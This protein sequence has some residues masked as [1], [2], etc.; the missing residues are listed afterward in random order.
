M[1]DGFLRI[2]DRRT[3][4]R[5]ATAAAFLVVGATLLFQ[6][7]PVMAQPPST[8]PTVRVSYHE[9]FWI[10]GPD[11]TALASLTLTPV[12]RTLPGGASV[13]LRMEPFIDGATGAQVGQ[14]SWIVPSP[15]EGHPDEATTQLASNPEE[16]HIKVKVTGLTQ[17]TSA[18]AALFAGPFQIGTVTVAREKVP[19]G[20]T[21]TRPGEPAPLPL[22][23]GQTAWL[24]ITNADSLAYPI[25]WTLRLGG[26]P[27]HGRMMVPAG[28]VVDLPLV[29][30]ADQMPSWAENLLRPG[31]R[32][33][34]LELAYEPVAG[35]APVVVRSFPV[36]VS[37][38]R[39]GPVVQAAISN[40]VILLLLLL[41]AMA[42]VFITHVVPL[43]IRRRKL[44][45]RLAELQRQ[46]SSLAR[47]GQAS[48]RTAVR[49]DLR[50]VYDLLKQARWFHTD[51]GAV[52]EDA[53]RTVGVIAQRI[54]LLREIDDVQR[55]VAACEKATAANLKDIGRYLDEAARL[56]NT[57]DLTAEQLV[58][59]RQQVGQARQVRCALDA[60]NDDRKSK[61]RD[62]HAALTGELAG[63]R[64]DETLGPLFDRVP[65]LA[66]IAGSA[67]AAGGGGQ[68][69]PPYG[70]DYVRYEQD[71]DR[72]DQ[73]A[74][75]VRTY[76]ARAGTDE[77]AALDRV[78]RRLADLLT[79]D[80]PQALRAAGLLVCQ[81]RE[82]VYAEKLL[83]LVRNDPDAARI[84]VSPR[85]AATYQT[86][87]FSLVFR[88]RALNTCAARESLV[89]VWEFDGPRDPKAKA[90]KALK[91]DDQADPS[92]HYTDQG[93]TLPHY[94]TVKGAYDVR[95]SLLDPISRDGPSAA[96]VT[97][98]ARSA[99]IHVY[100]R[101]SAG[102]VA[103][104]LLEGGRLFLLIFIA[105]A[106][107]VSGARQ[108]VLKLDLLPAV[109]TLLAIGYGANGVKNL[110]T[111][112]AAEGTS[113]GPPPTP[114]PPPPATT[115]PP[116]TTPPPPA[117][118]PTKTPPPATPPP[119]T[120]ERPQQSPQPA[121]PPEVI[122]A[123]PAAEAPPR[124]PRR[125]K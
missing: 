88:D 99:T 45:E 20:L 117:P 48:L 87:T 28:G 116:A 37:L 4:G 94:F 71:V 13:P 6:D 92:G 79:R 91:G 125:G 46:A 27:L 15:K 120:P 31:E 44:Y 70:D 75:F 77:R 118:A 11:G 51:V 84:E 21:M 7:L 56:L 59:A 119:A 49:V 82:G 60:T 65:V 85:N 68:P 42:S 63:Y 32:E 93:W 26:P 29:V 73:F 89:C 38:S 110:F 107:L 112:A 78:W 14:I 35:R 23:Q 43:S 69:A 81:V 47:T 62:R 25:N 108:Q 95:A 121:Q 17:T 96:T 111:T 36:R 101:H 123:T 34:T 105:L 57:P 122:A 39:W 97:Q 124:N 67:D 53:A 1:L 115:T 104:A 83:E 33:G 86:A 98:L 19:L 109:F 114:P 106:A 9:P 100:P 41:G 5:Y 90:A 2:G 64:K 58:A 16:I 22:V 102:G 76:A 10:E 80:G 72:L 12:V 24:T 30:A 55:P 50:R 18:T 8:Q 54:A 74:Q 113:S 61:L 66:A 40:L 3:A 52:F 103:R